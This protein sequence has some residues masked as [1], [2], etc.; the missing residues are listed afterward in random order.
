M[1]KA[2]FVCS[3]CH[4]ESPKWAGRCPHCGAWNSLEENTSQGPMIMGTNRLP[5]A[6]DMNFKIMGTDLEDISR[7]TIGMPEVDRVLGGG[8]VPGSAMVLGGEPG[9]GKSTI[10]IQ[11]ADHV[12]KSGKQVLY[13]S[14]EESLHQVKRRAARLGLIDSQVLLASGNDASSIARKVLQITEDTLLIIDSI[15]AMALPSL[16]SVPGSV[17]QVR[18]CAAEL[19][20]VCKDKDVPV[21]FVGHVTKDGSLAGPKVL[22]HA[23]DATFIFEG[24]KGLGHRLL[25]VQKNRF[26]ST[27]EVGVF[28]M[29]ETGMEEVSNPSELFLSSTQLDIP[30]CS[31]LPT[32]EGNRPILVEVQALLSPASYGTARRSVVGWEQSR[33]SMILAVLEA[34]CGLVLTDKDIHLNIV[35]GLKINEPAADMAVAASIISAYYDVTLPDS[36]VFFG[37]IGLAGEVRPVNNPSSRIKEAQK[38]GFKQVVA[39]ITKEEIPDMQIHSLQRVISLVHSLKKKKDKDK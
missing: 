31:I 38:L 34:R 8:I 13:V 5:S 33:L 11:I 15:Q 9:I 20:R 2:K 30:G 14:G 24:D 27:D 17:S 35:G 25:R 23:V 12:A 37:E 4:G 36:C 39:P 7:W 22:E 6:Q 18:A 29:T 10:L 26:G 32:I 3:E 28:A 1:K 19:I 16:D 21:I